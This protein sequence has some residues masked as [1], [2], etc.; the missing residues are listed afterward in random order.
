[1][2]SASKTD[3]SGAVVVHSW[4]LTTADAT[5]DRVSRPGAS[6]RTVQVIGTN[7]GS[8]T[9]ILEG[10]LNGDDW[11][12]LTDGQGNAISFTVDGGELVSENTL[13][14]RPRL[15]VGGTNADILVLLK[16]RSTMR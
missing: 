4:T 16:S 8:A 1:M 13:F 15:S 11:F 2:A 12:P 3:H 6:D 10:S 7:F 14:T 5:G 9:V